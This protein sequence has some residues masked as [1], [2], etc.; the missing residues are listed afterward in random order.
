MAI[1]WLNLGVFCALWTGHIALIVGIVNRVHAWPLPERA[2][3][4]TRRFH[5]LS[6]YVVPPLFAWLAGFR[7]PTLFRGG[8]WN[9][10]P[11]SLLAYLALCGAAALALPFVAISRRLRGAIPHSVA[12]RSRTIDVARRLGFR[13]LGPG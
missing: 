6:V 8:S 10:L 2:L 5:D 7:G 11:F 3:R 9:E 13:P 12:C 4:C 1:D